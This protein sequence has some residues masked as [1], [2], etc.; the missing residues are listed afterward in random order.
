MIYVEKVLNFF[1]S[2]FKLKYSEISIDRK[3]IFGLLLIIFFLSF[4]RSMH[5]QV[6]Y[7]SIDFRP[8]VTSARAF[9]DGMDPYDVNWSKDL[10]D[11]Y[12]DPKEGHPPAPMR[13][14]ITPPWIL[15][16]LIP[17]EAPYKLQAWI[18]WMFSW[19]SI[20]LSIILLAKSIR[21]KE[22]R[23]LFVFISLLFFCSSYFWRLHLERGQ[24][25][26]VF[27]LLF[28]ALLFNLRKNKFNKDQLIGVILGFLCVLRISYAPA[29]FFLLIFRKYKIFISSILT[30]LVLLLGSSSILG[31][32][33]WIRY[34]DSIGKWE[35]RL[36]DPK[37]SIL[38]FDHKKSYPTHAEGYD[39]TSFLPAR[40]GNETV[41][42]RLR[43]DFGINY[44][45]QFNRYAVFLIIIF[46]SLLCYRFRDIK[47]QNLIWLI[48]LTT[49]FSFDYFLPQR[50]LYVNIIFLPVLGLFFNLSYKSYQL[51][52]LLLSFFIGHSFLPFQESFIITWGKHLIFFF[53]L[54]SLIFSEIQE[55]NK[56]KIKLKDG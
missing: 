52:G 5:D 54:I 37:Q 48:I 20:L 36:L 18:W 26:I 30:S 51:F 19:L 23:L 33:V 31:S 32:D 4:L 12:L 16:N 40:G 25:Y 1:C 49:L 46:V 39:F 29:I 47:N 8:R 50:N 7:N 22:N 41:W 15:F 24:G 55:L 11:R 45:Y 35:E 43:D 44:N 56:N 14:V 53:V 3:I 10:S 42:V 9:L 17:A 34:F 38:K 6:R 28:S 21:K 2:I 13:M 27:T